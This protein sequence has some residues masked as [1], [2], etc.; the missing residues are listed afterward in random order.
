MSE[1][2]IK[3]VVDYNLEKNESSNLNENTY[4]GDN[5]I[6]TGNFVKIYQGEKI[7]SNFLPNN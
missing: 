7:D 4:C 5:T 1:D 3:V 2:L 6:S